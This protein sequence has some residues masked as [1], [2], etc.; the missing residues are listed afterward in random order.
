MVVNA[1]LALGALVPPAFLLAALL[2]IDWG[3]RGGL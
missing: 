1:L 2:N 3:D